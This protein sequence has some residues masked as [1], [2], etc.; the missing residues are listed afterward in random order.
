VAHVQSRIPLL[1]LSREM[2]RLAWEARA[3]ITWGDPA[4]AVKDWL[5]SSGADNQTAQLIIDTCMRERGW[6]LRLKAIRDL[7][8]GGGLIVLGSGGLV[9]FFLGIRFGPLAAICLLAILLGF[10]LVGR[11]IAP[12]L[13]G[14]RTR[15]ADSDVE[16]LF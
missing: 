15:G 16:D 4:D 3:R 5:I 10:S 6:S 12:L 11:A 14:A 13:R 9:I 2:E 8:I 1:N 7:L